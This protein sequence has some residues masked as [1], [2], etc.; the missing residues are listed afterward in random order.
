MGKHTQ[1]DKNLQVNYGQE[2][3]ED[4][5]VYPQMLIFRQFNPSPWTTS[6]TWQC[7]SMLP[8]VL[9]WTGLAVPSKIRAAGEKTNSD[10]FYFTQW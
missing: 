3:Q 2:A 4:I 8:I 1:S 10:M 9:G 5:Q 7:G 6:P